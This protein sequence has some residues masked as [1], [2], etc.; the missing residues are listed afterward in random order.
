MVGFLWASLALFEETPDL[1]AT[2]LRQIRPAELHTVAAARERIL[3]RLAE[4]PEGASLDQCLPDGSEQGDGVGDQTLR[5]RSGW[6]S[7]L[8]AGLELA[9]QGEVALGQEGLFRAI[10]VR[11]A[12]TSETAERPLQ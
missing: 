3:R 10:I 1:A 11:R 7:T 12:S 5:Q 8:V 4:R 9:R 2:T 6:A